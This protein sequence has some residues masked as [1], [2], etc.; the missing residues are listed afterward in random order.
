MVAHL[1][2]VTTDEIRALLASGR[3]AVALVPVGS[4]EPHGPHLPL[5][6][7]TIISEAAAARAAAELER[8]GLTVL[9][10]PAVPYG[11]TRVAEGFAGAISVPPA[12]LT[13][14]LGAVV[15]GYLDAGFAHVC[16]VNNHLEPEH[17][18]AVRAAIAGLPE[19]RASV[20]CP[21]TRRWARTLSAEFKSGACHAGRY[22]TSILLAAEPGAVRRE[23]AAS[24]PELEVSLSA[25]MKAGKATFLAMGLDHA[26]TG[27]PA[28]A[29][30]EEGEA[31]LDLLATMIATEVREALAAS[32]AGGREE[33][34]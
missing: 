7:D 8:A 1:G 29:T 25:G 15:Q 16:L 30:A 3:P 22:E 32:A 33:A 28:R 6:A 12:A 26:Y 9:L 18:A 4:V 10:A 27:A 2:R 5:A 17:D 11:V 13:A 20:A 23:V 19:G 24:L 34:P 31:T 14:F 21:L